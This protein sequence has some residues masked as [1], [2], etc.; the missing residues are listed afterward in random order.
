MYKNVHIYIYQCSKHIG[1]TAIIILLA[2]HYQRLE[3]T[4]KILIGQSKI[5]L[6][7]KESFQ[8]GLHLI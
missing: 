4:S 6:T 1:I 8:Q 3:V 2:T 5:P 7:L